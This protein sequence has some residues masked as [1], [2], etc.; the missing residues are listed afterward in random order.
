MLSLW[1]YSGVVYEE[2]TTHRIVNRFRFVVAGRKNR[3]L[4]TEYVF[5]PLYN[6][7]TDRVKNNQRI[8]G[9]IVW[10]YINNKFEILERFNNLASH[11]HLLIKYMKWADLPPY[12]QVTI[13]DLNDMHKGLEIVIENAPWFI[14]EGALNLS[15]MLFSDRLMSV[16]FSLSEDNAGLCVY[17][18]SIQG[19]ATQDVVEVYKNIAASMNDLRPRDLL[20]KIF[21]IF[22]D[23]IRISNIYCVADDYRVHNHAFFDDKKSEHKKLRYDELWRDQG[24]VLMEGGFYRMPARMDERPLSDVPTK[25]RGRYKRRIAMFTTISELIKANV[26]ELGNKNSNLI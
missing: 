15:M 7:L 8:M 25:K 6:I 19:S 23:S 24:G 5:G 12:R 17:V 16:S 9:F 21:R 13:A 11:Y 1:R 4:F 26:D 22:T 18:G 10:P 2:N 20:F 14:R 3:A